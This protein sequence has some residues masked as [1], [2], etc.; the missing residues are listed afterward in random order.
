MKAF[1]KMATMFMAVLMI[2]SLTANAMAAEAGEMTPNCNAAELVSVEHDADGTEIAVYECE[3]TPEATADG[4]YGIMPLSLDQTFTMGS[5]H[6]GGDRTYSGNKLQISVKITDANGNAVDNRVSVQ[7]HDYNHS[8]ALF[9]ANV[10]AD[11]GM[12]TESGISITPGRTYYFYYQVLSGASRTLK[13]RMIIT[14]YN[15]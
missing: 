9:S 2:C 6:R 12:K 1:K 11:G 13:V 7:L 14:D 15:G 10:N 8:Y 5:T 4:D 3:L